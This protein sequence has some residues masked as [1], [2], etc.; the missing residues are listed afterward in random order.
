MI[1]WFTGISG[2]GKT[3]I[4]NHLQKS[5]NNKA[6]LI[7]GDALRKINNNDLGYT[8]RDRDLNAKRMINLIEYISKQKINIIVC[9]NITS[10]RFRKIIKKKIKNFYEIHI[11]AN[12]NSLL[13]RDYKKL[14][15]NSFS[16]KI[17][18]VVGVDIDYIKPKN[19]FMYLENNFSKKNFLGNSK[20]IIQRIKHLL[21]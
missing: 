7:D 2:V 20:F 12:M 16:K 18:N 9:A 8:K 21:N 15:Q 4:A 14:Y 11:S 5:L 19:C 3:T 17:K 10:I 1:I 13:K 6:L